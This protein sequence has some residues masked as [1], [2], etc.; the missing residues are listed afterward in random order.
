[1]CPGQREQHDTKQK[2]DGS[3]RAVKRQ[4]Y[5]ISGRD[6]EKVAKDQAGGIKQGR[7]QKILIARLRS[8]NFFL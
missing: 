7:S 8:L 5:C 6:K 2:Q 1:M 4:V 3:L